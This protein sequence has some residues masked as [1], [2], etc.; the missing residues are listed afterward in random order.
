VSKSLIDRVFLADHGCA[1]TP[2]FALFMV[3]RVRSVEVCARRRGEPCG[4]PFDSL[5]PCLISDKY[6]LNRRGWQHEI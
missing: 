1:P 5:D 4:S 3:A 6:N 2:F